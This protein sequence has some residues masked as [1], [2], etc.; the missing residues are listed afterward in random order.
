MSRAT[1]RRA[2][3]THFAQ[4]KIDGLNT[5]YRTQPRIIPGDAFFTGSGGDESGAVAYVHL[6]RKTEH[7]IAPPRGAGKKRIIYD[8]ALVVLF[9][10]TRAVTVGDAQDPAE[11]SI[12]DHD[13][14]LDAI[15]ARLRADATLEG[16]VFSAGEG[17]E[18]HQDDIT[19][20][21]DLPRLEG[22]VLTI[23]TV[24]RF[25]VSEWLSSV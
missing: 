25:K 3:R 15:E 23:W 18:M 22:E 12:E 19:T 9:R 20:L 16:V 6:E 13:N 2:I 17:A 10:S 1:V 14:V 24:V 8:A 5:I 4:P 7:R 11:A 21:A